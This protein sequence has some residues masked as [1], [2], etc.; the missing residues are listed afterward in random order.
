LRKDE[1]EGFVEIF[2]ELEGKIYDMYFEASEEEFEWIDYLYQHGTPLGINANLAKEYIKYLTNSRLKAIGLKIIYP[3]VS[4]NPIPWINNWLH[5]GSTEGALQE[6]E[7]V[8]YKS[9]ALE[10]SDVDYSKF[11]KENE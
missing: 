11:F 10:M 8:D 2:K 6:I 4:K 3:G 7:S 1:D 5:F 9:G